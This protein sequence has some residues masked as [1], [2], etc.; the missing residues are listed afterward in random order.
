MTKIGHGV[1]KQ[2]YLYHEGP[3]GW[4]DSKG[5]RHGSYVFSRA[6]YLVEFPYFEEILDTLHCRQGWFGILR[7]CGGSEVGKRRDVGSDVAN[8][9]FGQARLHVLIVANDNVVHSC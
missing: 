4:G 9:G 8:I 6:G 3:C 2:C 1:R 5:H 7:L